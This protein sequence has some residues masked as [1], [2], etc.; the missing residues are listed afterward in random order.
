MLVA[1]LYLLLCSTRNR[2]RV[3]LRRLRE[4]RYLVGALVG[5]AYLYFS[6]FARVRGTHAAR[7]AG[8]SRGQEAAAALLL[9]YQPTVLGLG[10][11]ALL[12]SALLSWLFPFGSSLLEFSQAEIAFLLPAPVSPRQLMTHRLIRSQVRLLFGGAIAALVYPSTSAA[13]RVRVGLA[14]WLLLVTGKVYFTGVSLAR[15]RLLARTGGSWSAWAPIGMLSAAILV[16]AA[17]IRRAFEGAPPSGLRDVAARMGAATASGAARV[18]LWPFEALLR[19]L[20]TTTP[21]AFVGALAAGIVVFAAVTLWVLGNDEA[22]Q[23]AA[24]A[25][26]E[27]GGRQKGAKATGPAQRLRAWTLA[28]SGRPEATF[29]WKGV[30]QTVRATDRRTLS[31][32]GAVLTAFAIT[33]VVISQARGLAAVVGMFATIGAVVAVM[34]GPQMLRTDLRQDLLHLEMLRTWPLRP[35][36]V[37][38]GEMI[39][40]AALLTAIAWTLTLLALY[41]STPVFGAQRAALRLTV[42]GA[43][44]MLAPGL[45]ATQLA[46]QN[47]AVLMFPAWVPLGAGRPRGLDAMGQRLIMLAG[48]LL[49]LVIGVAP[50]AI[51]GGIVWFALRRLVGLAAV[52][53]GALVCSAV[54]LLE[55]L[56]A[57]EA[58]GPLYDRI[59]L[60]EVEGAEA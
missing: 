37:V 44:L 57:T 60:V 18:V 20:L 12:V 1:S 58:M 54:V 22:F 10:G 14:I 16:V 19:P 26:A 53:A 34:L 51:A 41:L 32:V 59:D 23:D 49:L 29:V 3:R 2:I 15:R 24:A 50:G 48:A 21:P 46:I 5:A 36:V 39:V 45:I 27:G 55:V 47:A 7:R 42:A 43:A 11:L 40:P 6:F 9:A 35:A 4:P 38:R 56:I 13:V 30:T 25:E 17:A 28:P 8:R 52:V 31:R 33:A